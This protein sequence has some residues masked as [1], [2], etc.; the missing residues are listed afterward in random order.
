VKALEAMVE[1]GRSVAYNL[2]TGR[3][4]SVREVIAAVE[5]VTGQSVARRQAPRRE[6]DPAVLY[7]AAQ[8]A[9]SELRWR[10]RWADIDAIV[11]TAWAWHRAHPD[12]Y[13]T[14]L[15]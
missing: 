12:G 4:H 9:Q 7:A 11:G 13:R 10:P 1:T 8:K 6:G 2:G 15:R 14:K 5:R 3:P